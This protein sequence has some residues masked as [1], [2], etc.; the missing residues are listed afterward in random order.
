MDSSEYLAFIPLLLYGLAAAELL[1]EWKR[2]FDRKNWFLPY[3]LLT[4]V[5]TEVAI[6]NVFIY[7]KLV[8]QMA[9]QTYLNYLIYLLPPFLFL[10]MVNS[11]TPDKEDVTKDYFEKN[12]PTFLMLYASFIATHFLFGFAENSGTI[13][14]RIISIVI[15]VLAGIFRKTWAIYV[16]AVGWFLLLLLRIDVITT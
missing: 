12:M 5:F 1:G 13:I 11:F 6:Y 2:L 14:G 10:L 8:N 7:V 16:I 4:I 9:G 3:L 15:I